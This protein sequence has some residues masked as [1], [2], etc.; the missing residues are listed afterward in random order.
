MSSNLNL[1]ELLPRIA[2]LSLQILDATTCKIYLFDKKK[3][4]LLPKVVINL[5]KINYRRKIR[6]SEEKLANKIAKS[7]TPILK[8]NLIAVPLIE[9][10][11]L[12]VI[13]VSQ[14]TSGKPFTYFDQDILSTLAEQAVVAIK[15]ARLFEQQERLTLGSIKSISSLLKVKEGTLHSHTPA[16][17]SMLS[18]IANELKISKEENIA[19][20]NAALLHDIEKVNIPD[21][22]LTKS[23]PLTSREYKII[24]ENPFKTIRILKPL[25]SLEPAIPIILHHH[26]RYDG[27]GYPSG[28]KGEQ[29]PMGARIMAIV[30]AFEAMITKRPWRKALSVSQA[31]SEIKKNSGTQFD[32][33]VVEAF[34][35]IIKNKRIRK[36]I[37]SRKG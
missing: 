4:I 31:I 28:L 11:V 25:Q 26:E 30:E 29:I 24:K 17:K 35:K 1:D 37:K 22:I 5:K 6:Q 36:K 12:G 34:L 14:K 13:L 19:L 9:E 16:F 23:K 8:D 10:E 20:Q 18:L 33:L 2:R 7:A 3:D 15:N 27:S 32:P 21:K